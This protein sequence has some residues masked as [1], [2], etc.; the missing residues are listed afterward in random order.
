[1]SYNEL[2]QHFKNSELPVSRKEIKTELL[3]V[4]GKNKLAITVSSSLVASDCRGLF[5]SVE[6]DCAWVKQHGCD[7]VVLSRDIWSKS[8]LPTSNYCMERFITVKEMMHLFDGEDEACDTGEDFDA[9]VAQFVGT[10][11]DRTPQFVS[12]IKCFWRALG[13]LCPED[14]RLAFADGD[15]SDY[16]I[17][18]QLRIPEQ[19]VENLFS[20]SFE[21]NLKMLRSI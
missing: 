18:L 13:L 16:E 3:N 21:P 8:K 15:L 6:S 1:M 7:V 10:Q 2:Y 20:T 12:E 11:A 14:K 9:L 4:T 5:A 19:Y 17:A